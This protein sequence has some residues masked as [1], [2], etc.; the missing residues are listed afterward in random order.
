MQSAL[1]VPI[2][3]VPLAQSDPYAKV[4]CLRAAYP[5]P[6]FTRHY[7]KHSLPESPHLILNYNPLRIFYAAIG[8]NQQIHHHSN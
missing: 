4:A 5:A 6:H 8:R 3:Q 1:L 7:F 2:F